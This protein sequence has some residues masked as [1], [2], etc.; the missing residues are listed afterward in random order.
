[1][2]FSQYGGVTVYMDG[3]HCENELLFTS[4]YVLLGGDYKAQ[5][6]ELIF[7]CQV[8][9]GLYTRTPGGADYVSHDDMTGIAAVFP[10][11]ATDILNYAERTDWTWPN[12][13]Q[14]NRIIDFPSHI[15]ASTGITLT[16]LSQILSCLG[17]LGGCFGPASS[18]SGR[19]L[20][21]IKAKVLKGKYPL[22]DLFISLWAWQM[23]RLYPNGGPSEMAQ[24][25]YPKNH[26]LISMFPTVF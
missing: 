25:Y 24:I 15:R 21:W 2:I 4:I 18:T 17:L 12:N 6:Q 14:L 3:G 8:V 19:Q 20:L 9:P 1:M 5:L 23:N 26:P 16:W 22:V 10:S 13:N 11:V 7:R